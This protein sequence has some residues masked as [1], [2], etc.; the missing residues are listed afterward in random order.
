MREN[1]QSGSEGREARMTCLALPLS[2]SRGGEIRADRHLDGG[3][4]TR[5]GRGQP[6]FVWPRNPSPRHL[7]GGLLVRRDGVSK[8]LQG[9]ANAAGQRPTLFRLTEKPE[10]S[11][12]GG[13]T[14][15]PPH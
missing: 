9:N 14:S 13:R 8:N 1:R 3:M 2:S 12:P 11:I 5:L 10:P 6:C 4:P 7:E 15:S